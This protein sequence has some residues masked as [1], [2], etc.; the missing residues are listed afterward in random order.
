MKAR[1]A[2]LV[3]RAQTSGRLDRLQQAQALSASNRLGSLFDR[4]LVEDILDVRLYRFGS[5]V[6]GPGDL[7]V[8]LS[9]SD[10]PENAALAR[11]QRFRDR[12]GSLRGARP[13]NRG[14]AP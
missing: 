12:A 8:R 13:I 14:P 2:L 1:G 3:R 7:F 10:Q 6:E 11:S 4:Q 5:D 9:F